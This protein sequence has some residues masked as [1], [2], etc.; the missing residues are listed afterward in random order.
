MLLGNM[1]GE[2]TQI[3]YIVSIKDD[4]GNICLIIWKF[5]VVKRINRSTLDTG[6]LGMEEGLENGVWIGRIW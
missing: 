1:K 2:K 3:G 6:T 5:K 4:E